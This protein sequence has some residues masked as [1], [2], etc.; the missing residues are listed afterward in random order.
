M[1]ATLPRKHVFVE[2]DDLIEA[3]SAGLRLMMVCG[4]ISAAKIKLPAVHRP[5]S[6]QSRKNAEKDHATN[7]AEDY[8]AVFP[9]IL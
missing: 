1:T 2:V 8:H 4:I 7:D 5:G 3:S 9:P 6:P